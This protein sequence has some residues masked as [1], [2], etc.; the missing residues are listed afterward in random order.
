M[1]TWVS[2]KLRLEALK[3]GERVCCGACGCAHCI[4]IPAW[5]NH[6]QAGRS[7]QD[8]MPPAPAKPPMT[9]PSI[10]LLTLRTFGFTISLLRVTW[11]SAMMTTCM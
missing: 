5:E 11:P 3:Q 4:N 2:F 9:V 7:S 1:Q 6:M 8:I 10:M